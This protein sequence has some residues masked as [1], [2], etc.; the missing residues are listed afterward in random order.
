MPV[1]LLGLVPDSIGDDLDDALD[2]EADPELDEPRPCLAAN[3]A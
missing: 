3:G 2:I 1:A